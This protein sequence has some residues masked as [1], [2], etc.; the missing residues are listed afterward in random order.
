ME[1]APESL[2]SPRSDLVSGGVWVVIGGAITAGAWT[3]DRLE[4]QGVPGF[5]APGLVPGILGVLITLAALGLVIRS[6]R[7]GALAANAQGDARPMDWRRAGVTLA[8]CLGFAVILVGHGL[9]FW[10]AAPVYLFL[11]I[12]LLQMPERRAAGQVARGVAVAAAIALGAG[13]GISMLFQHVF[14]VRLP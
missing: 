10:V 9:P 1:S 2:P 14:L 4:R 11:H 12:L 5:A 8:M 13:I 3:M 7:Q 6:V